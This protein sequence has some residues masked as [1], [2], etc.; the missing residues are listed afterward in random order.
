MERTDRHFRYFLRLLTKQAVLYTEMRTTGALLYGDTE[1]F[2]K[3]ESCEHPVALQM[4]GSDPSEMARCASLGQQAGYDEIN[5][6]VGCPSNRVQA[7]R[8]GACLMV[9][10][11]LV[12]RC[13]EYM[14]KVVEIPVT[15]KT[16][17]GIDKQQSYEFLTRFIS[18]VAAAGC[19][20]FIVH[21]RMAWLHGLS[22]KENR[23]IPPLRYEIVH[24]LKQDFPRLE[25]I[26]NG[27]LC[28]LTRAYD[29][30]KRV[31]GV[32]LGREVY[33]NP[34]MLVG[35]DELFYGRDNVQSSRHDVLNDYLPYIE[36]QLGEG[37]PLNAMTRHI[38]G[39]YQGLPG[40]R[41]WRRELSEHAW[42]TGAGIEVVKRAARAVIESEVAAN[43]C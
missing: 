43:A 4:G 26:L 27:G 3:F 11:G 22:P 13:V 9:E 1:R 23:N 6:N 30:L 2:L 42:K 14:R 12:A 15:V 16:R 7:G 25:I 41:R 40:S 29:E 18:T 38:I 35:V 24:R 34:Y 28:S 8:F 39:L 10:P 32:M 21:A 31:D 37:V 5:I 33:K 20:T 36:G 19:K 17:I